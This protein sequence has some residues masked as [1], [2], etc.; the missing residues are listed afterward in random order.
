MLAG[1]IG[2]PATLLFCG[3]GCVLGSLAFLSRLPLIQRELAP[4]YVQKEII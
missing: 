1:R 3:I 2:A 4:I